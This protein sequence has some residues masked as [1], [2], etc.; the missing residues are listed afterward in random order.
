VMFVN[1]G[2]T[3]S[4]KGRQRRRFRENFIYV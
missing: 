3:S 1:V 2:F 4:A